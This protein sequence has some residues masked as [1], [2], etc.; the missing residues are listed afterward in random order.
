[1]SRNEALDAI[2]AKKQMS[3]ESMVLVGG[4]CIPVHR[5]ILSSEWQSGLNGDGFICSEPDAD[6]LSVCGMIGP[7]E[8]KADATMIS[9]WMK[10]GWG[11][12]ILSSW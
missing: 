6:V 12:Q 11:A 5:K 10:G 9:A 1:M 2:S 8:G 3:G 4:V 7:N